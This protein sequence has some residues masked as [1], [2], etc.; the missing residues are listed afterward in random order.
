MDEETMRAEEDWQVEASHA[1]TAQAWQDAA[2]LEQELMQLR[3]RSLQPG[4]EH[5]GT[6]T[7]PFSSLP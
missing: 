4:Q 3:Q 2:G 1:R 7:L 5:N 6:T